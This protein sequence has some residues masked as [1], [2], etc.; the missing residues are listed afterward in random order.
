VITTILSFGLLAF[1]ATT[2]I[3][4]FGLTITI[5]IGVA[6][7]LSPIAGVGA[8]ARIGKIWA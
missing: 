7:L 6:F 5:G 8:R 4:A 3:R 2:A 1:S